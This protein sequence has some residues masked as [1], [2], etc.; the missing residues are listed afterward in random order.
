MKID[1]SQYSDEDLSRLIAAAGAELARRLSEG[2]RIIRRSS[3]PQTVVI[4]EPPDDDKDF[5]LYIKGVIQKGGYIKAGERRR[6][7]EIAKSYPAWV[8][9]QGLPD[10]SGT[11]AWNTARQFMGG[12]RAKER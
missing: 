5:V 4:N 9:R 7:A 12:G 11:G 2:D 6:V 8:R 10:D 1:L 3:P